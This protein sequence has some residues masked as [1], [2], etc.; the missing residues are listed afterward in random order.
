ML[1]SNELSRSYD[2]EKKNSNIVLVWY[3]VPWECI[4]LFHTSFEFIKLIFLLRCTL[5]LNTRTY[6]WKADTLTIAP[7][8]VEDVLYRSTS[9]SDEQ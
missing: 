6:P 8:I 2:N 5:D 9:Y 7:N 4:L 3:H 1:N